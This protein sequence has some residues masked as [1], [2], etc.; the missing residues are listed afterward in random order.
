MGAT[1]SSKLTGAV[2][3][4]RRVPF[5]RVFDAAQQQLKNKFGMQMV[6]LP[7]KEKITIKEKQSK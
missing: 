3:N 6:A 5:K 2:F 1:E 4:K 7:E